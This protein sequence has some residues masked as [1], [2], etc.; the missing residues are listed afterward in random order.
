MLR[1]TIDNRKMDHI[2]ELPKILKIIELYKNPGFWAAYVR[3]EY[4]QR[5]SFLIITFQLEFYPY[6]AKSRITL[7]S[8]RVLNEVHIGQ[9]YNGEIFGQALQT[10]FDSKLE[11]IEQLEERMNNY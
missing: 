3:T 11:T 1:G 9:K 10:F 5:K 2:P 8:V 6:P 7:E 4:E